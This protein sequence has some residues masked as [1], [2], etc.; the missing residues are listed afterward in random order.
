M[1]PKEMYE[2]AEKIDKEFYP[3]ILQLVLECGIASSREEAIEVMA[4]MMAIK[5]ALQIGAGLSEYDI[6]ILKGVA[7]RHIAGILTIE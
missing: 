4:E 3:E 5:V 1:P 6:K 7:E 2:M